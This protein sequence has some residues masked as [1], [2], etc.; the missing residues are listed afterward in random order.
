[1]LSRRRRLFARPLLP[2]AVIGLS[3]LLVPAWPGEAARARSQEL[4]RDGL[5]NIK[6]AAALVVDLSNDAVLYER[7]ADTVR[8]IASISKL[9]GALVI[10][11]ECKLDP[12]ALHEMTVAN[13]DAAKGGDKSKLTTGWR[14]SHSDLLHAALMRSDNRALP[15]LGE[16]CGMDTAKFGERMTARVRKLGLMKT[17]FKEPNGLSAENVSTARELVAV[18]REATKIQALTDVMSTR[19]HLLTAHNKEGKT[20]QIKIRNTDRLLSKNIA[21]IIG[22]KTGYTDIARY[23]FA[24]AARTL[25]G[26]NVA[27]VFLGAEGRHTRFAD[28]SRVIKWLEPLAQ[29]AKGDKERRDDRQTTESKPEEPAK[30]AVVRDAG[31]VAVPPDAASTVTGQPS[32]APK[33]PAPAVEAAP[34]P[35]TESGANGAALQEKVESLT[36]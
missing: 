27:M 17:F 35:K 7:D 2:S 13:R 25:E 16:A 1:M 33:E 4:T 6:S 26:R 21:T 14:Y 30:A 10:H 11:E 31:T 32:E 15:A 5:P 8:P 20:R 19:E 23:C 12:L 9:V 29:I 34:V 24:V 3:C 36:W 18:I 22:G 28:F